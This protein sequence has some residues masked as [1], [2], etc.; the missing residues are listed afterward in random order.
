V[1]GAP[2]RQW[3]I[4]EQ[5]RAVTMALA[6]EVGVAPVV[7]KL[8]M[9]RGVHD[10]DAAREF[11]NPTQKQLSDPFL[12]TDMLA[13]ADRIAEARER[14]EH[15][16][17]FGDYD[18]DGIAATA[19]LFT[20]LRRFGIPQVSYGMPQRLVEGY[21]INAEHVDAA[22]RDGVSL[23]ITVDNGVR[24]YAAA[25]RARDLGID[26]IITDHHS[27]DG[28]LPEAVAVVNPKRETPEHPAWR[29]CGAGIAF[30]L[31]EALNGTRNDLD[32][33]ALGTVADI[34]PLLGENRVIVTLGLKH[35][36]RYARTGLAQLA[37]VA[38]L[39]VRELRSRELGFQI[40]PRLNAAGRLSDGL[41]ALRLL[42]EED[43]T[44]AHVMALELHRAN[45][46]RR[47][48]EKAIYDDA[49]AELDGVFRPE[50]RT[51]VLARRGWHPGVIGIVATRVQ[52]CFYRPVLL[53]AI[54]E[55]GMG[56][57]S[58]RSIPGFDLVGALGACEGTFE[59]Y[60]G[61]QAAAGL[62]IREENIPAF[63]EAFEAEALRRL[64]P[65]EI[66]PVLEIDGPVSLSELDGGFMNTLAHLEPFG[67]SNPAP[68]FCALDVELVPRS[69][70]LLNGG[71]LRLSVRQGGRVFEAVGFGFA[72]WMPPEAVPRRLDI[73][74]VP[75]LNTYRN[76]TYVQLVLRDL[77]PA[78][79]G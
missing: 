10:G 6:R 43:T 3:R 39:K 33:A 34:V 29:L 28:P 79:G 32:L 8:L 24:A 56:K 51:I 14:G 31:S 66:L 1:N 45:D 42:L 68:L 22:S 63:R 26:L 72:E 40:A 37:S 30:K 9:A 64:G 19:I 78:Q 55:N 44:A 20:G 36:A 69:P 74:F 53:V 16:R 17:V 61:H 65:D 47:A 38:G 76:E 73:A 2:K 50:Q 62:T 67:N 46:D 57:G 58:G 4:G 12:L 49:V 77:R 18:V 54:D 59:Q 27:I 48:I 75:E 25:A 41:T 5:D 52:T 60:G 21:G 13:A 70:R 35:M 23:I 7:A 71:H 15:V 11:L